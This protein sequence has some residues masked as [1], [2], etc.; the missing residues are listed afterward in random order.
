MFKSSLFLAGLGGVAI[1]GAIVA[2][3]FLWHDNTDE[4]HAPPPSP[5]V[6]EV[7]TEPPA[8]QLKKHT[9]SPIEPTPAPVTKSDKQIVPSFDVVRIAPDGNAVIAGQAKSNS[10]VVITDN[11]QFVGQINADTHGEWVFVPE[12]PFTPGSRQLGLEMHIDG[13]K[14]VVSEDV[15]VLVVPEPHKDIAGRKT[16]K[17]SQALVLKFPEN[18]GPS[19]VLQKPAG[20]ADKTILNV[21]TVDYDKNGR[22]MI[23][24]RA[25]PG[26]TV[27]VYMN[28][29][30]TGTSVVDQNGGWQMRPD[31]KITPGLYTLRADQVAVNGKVISRISMP[32][33]RAEPMEEM[34]S[35]PFI[36]VQPGNSLWRIARKAYGSGFNFTTIYEANIDQIKN[37]DMI[38]PGQVFV[39][40][41]NNN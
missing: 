24:G 15:V 35:S 16:D 12:K 36:I 23:S 25:E 21:D 3:V 8:A 11:G 10:R 17:P 32:F 14:P 6:S 40:P 39:L 18:G 2:N 27:F 30:I 38:F 5:K 7:I 34:P 19:T 37:P 28:N 26:T 31:T 29:A 4:I 41:S 9:P 22:L 20:D 13:E 1:A 33:S